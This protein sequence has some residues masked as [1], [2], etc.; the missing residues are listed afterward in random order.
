MYADDTVIYTSHSKISFIEQTLTSEMNNVSKWLDK[1]RLITNLNK[2]KTDSLLFG[3]AKRLSSKD[4]M[5][6][7][8]N[9][10]LIKVTAEYKY[11]GVWLEPTLNM[12]EHLQKVLRKANARVKGLSCVRDSLSVFAAKEVRNS[13][14]LPTI[15]YCSTPVV[16]VSDTMLKKFESVQ[17]RA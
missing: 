4:P 6:V 10:K 9:E 12:N 5:D 13:F 2:G 7:Y 17:N 14:I 11:L 3:T 15:L 1:N 16:K 8:M